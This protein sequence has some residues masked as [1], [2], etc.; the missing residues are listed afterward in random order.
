[1]H[2][3]GIFFKIM[4][5]CYVISSSVFALE[6]P[7]L[8]SVTALSDSSIGLAWRNNDAA[9]TGTIILRKLASESSY[10]TVDSIKTTT[11]VTYTDIK[12][13]MPETSYSYQLRAFN[14]SA[15]SDT[16]NSVNATTLALTPVFIA[17]PVSV[18][19]DY[20]TS[21]YP[22]IRIIDGSNCESGYRIYRDREF[23][24][25][26]N[27]ISYHP[28]ST[29]KNKEVFQIVDT[30]IS[31]NNWYTYKISAIKGDS[32]RAACCT[33]FTFRSI[34]AQQAVRFNKI[35]TFP[36]SVDSGWSAKVG[37]SIILK[38][39]PSPEGKFSVLNVKDPK[40]PKFEGYAD[41][42]TLLNY[43]AWTLIPTFLKY[44]IDDN[45][46]KSAIIKVQ[47]HILMLNKPSYCTAMYHFKINGTS[48][49]FVDSIKVDSLAGITNFGYGAYF[50]EVN[51]IN[52]TFFAVITKVRDPAVNHPTYYY[53]CTIFEVGSPIGRP[54][55]TAPVGSYSSYGTNYFSSILGVINNQVLIVCQ[56]GVGSNYNPQ[57]EEAIIGDVFE[58]HIWRGIRC[59]PFSNALFTGKT[60]LK[61]NNL[62]TNRWYMPIGTPPG[63]ELF[64][65]HPW[66][67]RG[68]ETATA[69]NA[70]YVDS[71][72]KQNMLKN[73]FAD[74]AKKVV[75]LVFNDVLTV[76]GYEFG[77][78]IGVKHQAQNSGLHNG[79]FAIIPQGIG[80]GVTFML[81]SSSLNARMEI[82]DIGGR[83]IDKLAPS[84]SNV[85]LWQPKVRLSGCYIAVCRIEGKKY[86]E[87][88]FIR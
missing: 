76:L 4:A 64:S 59:E 27:E 5:T 66:D 56:N 24:G 84:Q 73:I 87:R 67:A 40:D 37:D 19:W 41:S 47:N 71:T 11:Q 21:L 52:D 48:V 82:Y 36:L 78:A 20:D 26:F 13:L 12:G 18:T 25:T 31:L 6:A 54:P 88:F 43:P 8:I 79:L 14:Q 29:P 16:S 45:Y 58:N 53:Y 7:Y 83:V 68:Y 2:T 32:S 86:C 80:R 85:V 28:S 3:I 33:T 77:P 15:I 55:L 75:Y 62:Y 69:N 74:T 39:N 1:M 38:E 46:K 72:H 44:G 34:K 17:P 70:I 61:D 22:I 42:A 10:K 50:T 23:S 60:I 49:A 51:F 35:G 57:N 9:A 63:V 81:P 30:G 65:A